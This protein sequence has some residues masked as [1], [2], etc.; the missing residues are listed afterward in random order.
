VN[1]YLT[2]G[3]VPVFGGTERVLG[4]K[5]HPGTLPYRLSARPSGLE[6]KTLELLTEMRTVVY[7]NAFDTTVESISSRRMWLLRSLGERMNA[8]RTVSK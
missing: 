6:P 3:Q 7:L 5:S 1:T 4:C 8:T 2:H